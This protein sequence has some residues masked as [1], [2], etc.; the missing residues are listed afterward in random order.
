MPWKQGIYFMC[1]E[2]G[3]CSKEHGFKT[4]DDAIDTTEAIDII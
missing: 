4:I 2:F 1:K 3:N